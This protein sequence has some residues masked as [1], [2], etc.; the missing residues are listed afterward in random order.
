MNRIR[1][2]LIAYTAIIFFSIDIE[3]GQ[4]FKLIVGK[5]L[6]LRNS[7]SILRSYDVNTTAMLLTND[8]P[9]LFGL[10]LG[11]QFRDLRQ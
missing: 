3:I 10:Q 6:F 11:L 2:F 1:T 5:C 7:K 9:A 4:A 8:L